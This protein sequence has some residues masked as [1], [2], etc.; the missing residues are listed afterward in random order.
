MCRDEVPACKTS[1]EG[2][3]MET[4][5]FTKWMK[6]VLFWAVL[7][8]LV[9]IV[10][11]IIYAF[12]FDAW[13]TYGMQWNYY[14]W[15]DFN[16]Q[17]SLEM[18][19]L[20]LM[21]ALVGTL[22]VFGGV[23]ILL[24]GLWCYGQLEDTQQG[25]AQQK[26]AAGDDEWCTARGCSCR[27]HG[28]DEFID[29]TWRVARCLNPNCSCVDHPSEVEVDDYPC[30]DD[31]CRCRSHGPDLYSYGMWAQAQCS[32]PHCTCEGHTQDGPAFFWPLFKG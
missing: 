15:T 1:L 22:C 25:V 32:D 6:I 11:R 27:S 10:A 13:Q 29:G 19:K 2:H 8:L 14:F 12:N 31:V 23:L 17:S 7:A 21:V 3:F 9:D 26:P 4:S 16:N 24:A 18:L 20:H 28:P 5:T 30:R